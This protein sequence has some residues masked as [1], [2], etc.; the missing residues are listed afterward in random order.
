MV[1]VNTRL[2][3]RSELIFCRGNIRAL[4]PHGAVGIQEF[5]NRRAAQLTDR[6]LRIVHTGDLHHDLPLTGLVDIGLS[7]AQHV[8]PLPQHGDGAAQPVIQR[9]LVHIRRY[10]GLVGD[11][12]A[13]YQ[14]QPQNHPINGSGKQAAQPKQGCVAKQGDDQ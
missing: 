2:I 12:G 5:H 3:H 7:I 6:F 14:I 4:E 8:Q 1:P 10:L 11:L 13:A 9:G